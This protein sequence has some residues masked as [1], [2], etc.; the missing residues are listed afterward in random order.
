VGRGDDLHDCAH[1]DHA[2]HLEPVHQ[3]GLVEPELD[4]TQQPGCDR[5]WDAR[6]ALGLEP[7]PEHGRQLLVVLGEHLRLHG[8]LTMLTKP[9]HPRR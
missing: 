9:P 8:H 7:L 5:S 2:E 6:P 1:D 3:R 4:G